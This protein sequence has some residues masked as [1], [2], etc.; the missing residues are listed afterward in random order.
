MSIL[1]P[2]EPAA[3]GEPIEGYRLEIDDGLG[4]A[5]EL[6]YQGID[7]MYEAMGLEVNVCTE[8]SSYTLPHTG[9]CTASSDA[10]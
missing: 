1:D 4:G 5:F 10:V 9:G 2:Q 3:N 6:A 7:R 8:F